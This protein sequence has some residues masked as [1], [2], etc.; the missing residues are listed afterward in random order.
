[1][2]KIFPFP[3]R[4]PQPMV[5]KH[6]LAALALAG[7]LVV[8]VNPVSGEEGARGAE[9]RLPGSIGGVTRSLP[10]P[11]NRP[12]SRIP[13]G[14]RPIDNRRLLLG[15]SFSSPRLPS[16]RRPGVGGGSALPLCVPAPSAPPRD[17]TRKP[18][19][20]AASKSCPSPI[21]SS[22]LPSRHIVPRAPKKHST[23]PILLLPLIPREQTAT[24]QGRW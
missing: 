10:I 9:K 8:S 1:M 12:P 22:Y 7:V 14:F 4:T 2:G 23:H 18:F 6:P 20:S 16:R 15:I 13:R 19:S 17:K 5:M 11:V 24:R 3:H 21:P